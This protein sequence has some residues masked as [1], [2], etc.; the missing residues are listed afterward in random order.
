VHQDPREQRHVAGAGDVPG[1]VEA[2]GAGRSACRAG[3][4]GRPAGS[5]A[6]RSARRSLP[7]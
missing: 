1:R 7:T 4:A 6:R 2:V 3:R 5:S